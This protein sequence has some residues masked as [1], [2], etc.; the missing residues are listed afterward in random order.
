MRLKRGS[1]IAFEKSRLA[2]KHG[3]KRKKK[4]KIYIYIYIYVY[5][6]GLWNVGPPKGWT[7][8]SNFSLAPHIHSFLLRSENFKGSEKGLPGGVWRPSRGRIPSRQPPL[9]ASPFSKLLRNAMC[10]ELLDLFKCVLQADPLDEDLLAEV[11]LRHA[12]Q[13]CELSSHR[14]MP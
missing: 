4:K 7:G 6:I 12:S 5:L 10:T 14:R 11:R 8:V 1:E 13:G 3:K 9:S 2:T